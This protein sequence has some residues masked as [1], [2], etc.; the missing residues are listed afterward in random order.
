MIDKTRLAA[1]Y[2]GR[3][4]CLTQILTWK[5]GRHE[6]DAGWQRLQICNIADVGNAIEAARQNLR[7]GRPNLGK[8]NGFMTGPM[9]P[10]LQSANAR[11]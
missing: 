8:H 7:C 1:P 5:S 10:K 6:V 11:E 4:S 2:S 9:K 3:S